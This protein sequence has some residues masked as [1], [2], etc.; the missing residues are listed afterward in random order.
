MAGIIL[1]S[2]DRIF[3]SLKKVLLDSQIIQHF[4]CA[5]YG[6]CGNDHVAAAVEC[7]LQIFC[8]RF[9]DA[10][11]L[12]VEA[13][14]VGGFDYHKVGFV[15]GDRV[16]ED[17]L[18]NIAHVPGKQNLSFVL[19]FLQP[20][21]NGCRAQQVPCVVEANGY[22]FVDS[23]QCVLVTIATTMTETAITVKL[24]RREPFLAA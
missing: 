9:D 21:F 12:F 4:L 13:V 15:N 6:K 24:K 16:A 3:P 5:A 23:V 14:T 20:Y 17:G 2:A 19:S 18:V 22:V 1:D 10:F 11:A 7:V 8:E